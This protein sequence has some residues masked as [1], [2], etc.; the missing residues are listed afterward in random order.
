MNNECWF[1]QLIKASV[2]VD[3]V[4]ALREQRG[5]TVKSFAVKLNLVG[6]LWNKFSGVSCKGLS[7]G[8]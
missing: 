5:N 3:N 6:Q 7:H 2:G 1:K 4:D 8:I